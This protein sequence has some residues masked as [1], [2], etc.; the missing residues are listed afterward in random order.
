LYPRMSL[1]ELDAE[2]SEYVE[3]L[4]SKWWWFLGFGIV[5]TLFGLWILF[6]NDWDQDSITIFF[7][8][9]LLVWGAFRLFGSFAYFGDGKWWLMLSGAVG[10]GLGIA[11]F[12]WPDS[13]LK[14][15]AGLT[16]LWLIVSGTL[17]I[18][19]GLFQK[20][21]PRWLLV[22][23]GGLA[24]LLGIWL[25]N[26]EVATLFTIIFAMGLGALMFGILEIVSSFQIKGL[27]ADY[28]QARTEAYNQLNILAD[29]H[30]KGV[31]S[32]EEYAREKAKI[33]IG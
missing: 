26:H 17:N 2:M 31:L 8:I 30:A 27:P 18:I 29:L 28:E 16:A 10:I 14:V 6:W 22:V 1:A 3:D 33:L 25:W 4:A 12:V 15:I 23:W 11:T 21:E 32:D 19:G 20:R 24:L 7:G 9:F 5:S 13:T